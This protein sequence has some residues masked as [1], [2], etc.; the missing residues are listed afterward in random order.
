MT[1]E[2]KIVRR[3]VGEIE[4]ELQQLAA[5]CEEAAACPRDSTT[6]GLRARGSIL[7]DF[8]GGVER[9]FRRIAEEVDGGLPQGD[10]WHQQLLTRMTIE[11]REV[12]LAVVTSGLASRLGDY[13]RFRH[14]FR[15]VY[16]NVLKAER[17]TSL[18]ERLPETHRLF[19]DELRAFLRWMEGTD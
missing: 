12:R 5:I 14:V 3:V 17:L 19:E 1:P 4:E 7:H 16:G 6:F 18:E 13:L 10:Q 8:Y 2:E 11:I 9:V 15:N